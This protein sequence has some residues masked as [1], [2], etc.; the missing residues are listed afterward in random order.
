MD[1]AVGGELNWR[2]GAQL[3]L[4]CGRLFIIPAGLLR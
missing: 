2:E 3:A 4:S 1:F